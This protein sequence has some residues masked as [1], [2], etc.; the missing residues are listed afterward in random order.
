MGTSVALSAA[1]RCDPLTEPVILIEKGRLGS[2]SS[3]RTGAVIHQ[4]YPERPLAGMA[5]DALKAYANLPSNF[6]RSVG[7]RRT[8]V[9]VVAGGEP[10]NV[11]RLKRDVEMQRSI[12]IN[13]QLVDAPKM[14]QIVPGIEVAAA[15]TTVRP[16][17][18]TSR[19]RKPS[20]GLIFKPH[21]PGRI[22][23]MPLK[24]KRDEWLAPPMRTACSPASWMIMSAAVTSSSDS[25][26]SPLWPGSVVAIGDGSLI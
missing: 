12:G 7:Y 4:G 18:W 14:R 20:T 25:N 2:G 10:D 8:G 5:R 3:G 23:W 22:A 13:V 9:L 15:S 19:T 21:W 1:K 16:L 26:S 17:I 6:G 24:T 11:A